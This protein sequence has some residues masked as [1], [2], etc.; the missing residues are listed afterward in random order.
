VVK[1]RL[2]RDHGLAWGI[3]LSLSVAVLLITYF[4]YVSAED[5]YR[6]TAVVE[7]VPTTTEV[8]PQL[9]EFQIPSIEARVVSQLS[10]DAVRRVISVDLQESSWTVATE[11]TLGSG[12]ISL[13]VESADEA[14]VIPVANAYASRLVQA[15]FNRQALDI[16]LISAATEVDMIST[17]LIILVAGVGLALI[18]PLMMWTFLAIRSHAPPGGAGGT[19]SV[20]S[21]AGPPLQTT[22]QH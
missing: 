19:P 7:V 3:V 17:K 11:V 5:R 1:G 8:S 15:D 13:T 6:A 9:L 12:V 14:V 21:D 2:V 10:E 18:L 22:G 20:G 4:A 16:Q